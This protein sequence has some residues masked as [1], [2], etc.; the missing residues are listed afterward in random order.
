MNIPIELRS[1]DTIHGLHWSGYDTDAPQ[2]ISWLASKGYH[3]WYDQSA[4]R[5]GFNSVANSD[6][7]NYIKGGDYIVAD[8]TV[9]TYDSLRKVEEDYEV[10][11]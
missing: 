11:G 9:F 4:N 6:V 8:G 3:A 1:Y 2:V 7:P 5:I 10:V